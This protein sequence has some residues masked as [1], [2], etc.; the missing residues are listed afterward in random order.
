MFNKE[1]KQIKK[2]KMPIGLPA[3]WPSPSLPTLLSFVLH[4]GHSL[5][6]YG[7]S[8]PPKHLFSS[9]SFRSARRN[10]QQLQNRTFVLEA[11]ASSQATSPWTA[12]GAAPP[13]PVSLCWRHRRRR[14]EL[15]LPFLSLPLSSSLFARRDRGSA[16]PARTPSSL[17]LWLLAARPAA[18]TSSAVAAASR[19]AGEPRPCAS[20]PSRCALAA[21]PARPMPLVADALR[22]RPNPAQIS[23]PPHVQHLVPD[24]PWPPW[25]AMVTEPLSPIP[26]VSLQPAPSVRP[27]SSCLGLT[28]SRVAHVKS[29]V[30][31]AS[32]CYR[33]RVAQLV[34][35]LA[36]ACAQ[37]V[38]GTSSI[39]RLPLIYP[40]CAFV[41]LAI[42]PASRIKSSCAV[43]ARCA[44]CSH[45]SSCVLHT[46]IIRLT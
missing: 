34:R 45:V 24:R 42:A 2:Q 40:P 8:A 14:G 26:P 28:D 19:P 32:P 1:R 44:C 43:R 16:E 18:S 9:T 29:R 12:V 7:R 3:I 6:L 15:V 5:S 11:T 46:L 35:V 27:P 25:L 13:A 21:C 37:C 20:Q 39:L 33:S 23:E 22:A 38:D 36:F 31:S 17:L 4:V 41:S 30:R 10:L